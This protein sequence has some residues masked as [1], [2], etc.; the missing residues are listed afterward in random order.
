MMSNSIQEII[1]K[2]QQGRALQ[3]EMTV[4]KKCGFIFDQHYSRVPEGD[5]CRETSPGV[6]IRSHASR[7]PCHRWRQ[8]PPLR[9]NYDVKLNFVFTK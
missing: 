8:R 9:L 6:G 7:T 3:F 4:G 1:V 5:H 2:Y